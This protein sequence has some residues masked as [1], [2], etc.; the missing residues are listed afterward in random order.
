MYKIYDNCIKRKSEIVGYYLEKNIISPVFSL[1]F[2][3]YDRGWRIQWD[4]G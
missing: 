4:L 2:L 1:I 3:F